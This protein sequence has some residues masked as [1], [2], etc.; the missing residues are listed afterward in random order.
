MADGRESHGGHSSGRPGGGWR[1]ARTT[2][3]TRGVGRESG[4]GRVF[5]VGRPPLG[6]H[7]LSGVALARYPP[8]RPGPGGRPSRSVAPGPD[9]DP[10]IWGLPWM[11]SG[12]DF[13]Q[14]HRCRTSPGL[15]V[16]AWVLDR[17]LPGCWHLRAQATPFP[18]PFISK[19]PPSPFVI[20][21]GI[22]RSR[23]VCRGRRVGELAGPP[24]WRGAASGNVPPSPLRRRLVSMPGIGSDRDQQGGQ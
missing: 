21:R 3:A 14:T 9:W 12:P 16:S 22:D 11:R 7:G 5:Q 18:P 4:V 20:V 23:S 6:R 19:P 1:C 15:C 24:P 8:C 13:S 17:L 10:S 2:R